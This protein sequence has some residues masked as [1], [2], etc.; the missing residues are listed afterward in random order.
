ME[1]PSQTTPIVQAPDV[2]SA[3]ASALSLRCLPQSVTP[4]AP[5]STVTSRCDPNAGWSAPQSQQ[6]PSGATV[7]PHETQPAASPAMV[8]RGPPG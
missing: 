1:T 3:I 7:P 8:R 5:P 4:A 2:A 6:W